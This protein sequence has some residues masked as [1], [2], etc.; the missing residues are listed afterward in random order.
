HLEIAGSGTPQSNVAATSPPTWLDQALGIK[1]SV[2]GIGAGEP[3]VG[4]LQDIA[5]ATGGLTRF[6]TTPDEA[7]R[8]F[9]VEEL[10]NA[11]RGFSPQLVGY[12]RG[13]VSAS[14][15]R[16]SFALNPAVRKLVL[17]LSWKA[18]RKLTFRVERNG[19]DVTAT[20]TIV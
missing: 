5:T 20:G 7:L 13:V 11:L 12:R 18:G 17:K 9:F 19:V 6:T 14:T 3:F 16:E 8:R 1:V 2:I 4:L 10:I 15:A